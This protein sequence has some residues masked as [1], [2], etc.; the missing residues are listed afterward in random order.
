[1]TEIPK[2]DDLTEGEQRTLTSLASTFNISGE[3][4]G[5]LTLPNKVEAISIAIEMYAVSKLI[6]EQ[7]N[8]GK[9]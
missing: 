7:H 4:V 8:S 6:I 2:W 1:M 9:N 5:D 3:K